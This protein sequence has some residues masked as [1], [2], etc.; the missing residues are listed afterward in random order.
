[1]VADALAAGERNAGD[2]LGD[3]PMLL[4]QLQR[5]F[6]V[7]SDVAAGRPR[8][9]ANVLHE[10][11]LA[12]AVR[13]PRSAAAV[14]EESSVEAAAALQRRAVGAQ[15]VLAEERRLDAALVRE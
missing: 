13:E 9:V 14:P 10:E 11:P 8:L 7:G 2:L 3:Q 12:E 5:R 4:A 15:A 6:D 1:P